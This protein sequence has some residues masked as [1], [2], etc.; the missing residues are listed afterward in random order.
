MYACLTVNTNGIINVSY[1]YIQKKIEALFL[2][3]QNVMGHKSTAHIKHHCI[4]K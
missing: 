4:Y 1:E 3:D 2:N